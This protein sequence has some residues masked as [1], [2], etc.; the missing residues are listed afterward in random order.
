MQIEVQEN[1]NCVASEQFVFSELG[2]VRPVRAIKIVERGVETVCAVASVEEGGGFGLARAVKIADSGAG[3]AYLIFGGSWGIRLKPE[4]FKEE[5]WD[6]SSP[7]Q[8][9]E[10]FKIYGEEEDIIYAENE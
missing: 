7:H 10:P 8:Q 5:A 2:P 3:Y 6:L 4:R 9:G 1:S